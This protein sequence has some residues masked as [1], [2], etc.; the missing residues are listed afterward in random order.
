MTKESTFKVSKKNLSKYPDHC[1]MPAQHRHQ[2]KIAWHSPFHHTG[3]T[4]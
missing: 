3:D 2:S 1:D 4:K